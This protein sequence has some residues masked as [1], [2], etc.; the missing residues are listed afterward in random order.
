MWNSDAKMLSRQ[1]LSHCCVA[2]LSVSNVWN[3]HHKCQSRLKKRVIEWHISSTVSREMAA[4]EASV[5]CLRSCPVLGLQPRLCSS[6]YPTSRNAW[7]YQVGNPVLPLRP[8]HLLRICT[9]PSAFIALGSS[10]QATCDECWSH[11]T[12]ISRRGGSSFGLKLIKF[13]G[14]LYEK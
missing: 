14:S 11:G 8:I 10:G 13:L 6:E 4:Q 2:L 12:L 7:G 1:I 3:V 9:W 5:S